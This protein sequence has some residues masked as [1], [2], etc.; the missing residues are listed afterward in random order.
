MVSDG[1]FQKA[2]FHFLINAE[3]GHVGPGTTAGGP[4]NREPG[5]MKY[6]PRML[7][8]FFALFVVGVV[9][10]EAMT[11]KVSTKTGG[12]VRRDAHPFVY[13]I[14]TALGICFAVLLLYGVLRDFYCWARSQ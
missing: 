7:R 11:G 10:Y 4:T 3:T 1:D 13:W 6:N 8:D 5:C 12:Y 2:L 14:S 9:V